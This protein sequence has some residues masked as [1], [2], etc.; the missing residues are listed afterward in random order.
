MDEARQ[1]EQSIGRDR[2]KMLKLITAKDI[3]SVIELKL[4]HAPYPYCR[5][6]RELFGHASRCIVRVSGGCQY[7]KKVWQGITLHSKNC[8]H[9]ACQLL[10]HDTIYTLF[11][12]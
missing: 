2:K 6:I 10:L 11:F 3:P 5:K 7:C 8:A 1:I 4:N 9:S 12:M